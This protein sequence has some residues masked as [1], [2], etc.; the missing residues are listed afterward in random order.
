M[1]EFLDE[2]G[3]SPEGELNISFRACEEGELSIAASEGGLM[4]SE[5]EDSAGLPPSGV[6]AQSEADVEL[7]A[8]LAPVS[9]K[10]WAGVYSFTM[11]RVLAVGRLVPGV[12]DG[13]RCPS[14][15]LL[16]REAVIDYE[17]VEGTVFCPDKSCWLL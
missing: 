1:V 12:D 11:P 17:L 13:R 7:A 16:G 4:P 15:F 8:V 9:H 6:L 5:V 3:S 14:F 10:H 2:L